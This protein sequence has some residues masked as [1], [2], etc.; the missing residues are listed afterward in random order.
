MCPNVRKPD[1]G[2][3]V[4]VRLKR[5]CSATETSLNIEILH[6]ASLDNYYTLQGE[7]NKGADQ[8]V[9]MHRLVFFFVV[10]RSGFLVTRPICYIICG[11]RRDNIIF[12]FQFYA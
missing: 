8:T 12:Y 7:S 11:P 6:E 3:C 10:T 4:K 5:V 2:V 9:Q 1:F